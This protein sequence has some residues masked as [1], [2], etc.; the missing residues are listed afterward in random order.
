MIKQR[1][2]VKLVSAYAVLLYLG[3]SAGL[4]AASLYLDQPAKSIANNA[5]QAQQWEKVANYQ[6]LSGTSSGNDGDRAFSDTGSD[7]NRG[8]Y[9]LYKEL[10]GKPGAYL[11]SSDYH[12]PAWLKDASVMSY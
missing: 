1:F 12:S 6:I 9:R 4:V 11:I 7:L 5:K 10:E 3:I 8:A 2:P